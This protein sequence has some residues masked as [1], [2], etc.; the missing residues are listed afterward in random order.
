MDFSSLSSDVSTE[1]DACSLR[2]ALAKAQDEVRILHNL[3]DELGDRLVER[4]NELRWERWINEL[5]WDFIPE[6]RWS[7]YM[8]E[9]PCAQLDWVESPVRVSF[10]FVF[11]FFAQLTKRLEKEAQVRVDT[12]RAVDGCRLVTRMQPVTVRVHEV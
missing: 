7:D 4:G 9:W 6:A 2:A 5:A 11:L 8:E 10:S 12:A 3:N 1:D